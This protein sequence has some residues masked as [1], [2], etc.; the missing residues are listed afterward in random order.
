MV[1]EAIALGA[2]LVLG[3]APQALTSLPLGLQA[4]PTFS[5]LRHLGKP[6]TGVQT[7]AGHAP[8]ETPRRRL[9]AC[10]EDRQAHLP[11]RGQRF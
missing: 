5:H 7:R 9:G 6:S 3:P 11:G 4:G 2:R 1:A 8:K 10:P